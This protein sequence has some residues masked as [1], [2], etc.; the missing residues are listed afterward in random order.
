MEKRHKLQ[1]IGLVRPDCCLASVFPREGLYKDRQAFFKGDGWCCPVSR[2]SHSSPTF[3]YSRKRG[4]SRRA[5]K[6]GS[7]NIAFFSL[8]GIALR[9]CQGADCFDWYREKRDYRNTRH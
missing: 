3:S 6:T 7:D 2:L 1:E 5:V 4:K 9:A 8:Y